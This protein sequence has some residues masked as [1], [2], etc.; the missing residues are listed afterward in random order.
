MSRRWWKLHS[1]H[2]WHLE[3]E[4]I[5]TTSFSITPEDWV[6]DAIVQDDWIIQNETEGICEPRVSCWV[7]KWTSLLDNWVLIPF[8]VW[9]SLKDKL[10]IVRQC[11]MQIG[12]DLKFSLA[13]WVIAVSSLHEKHGFSVRKSWDCLRR[14]MLPFMLK[15]DLS[16]MFHAQGPQTAGERNH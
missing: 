13:V 7:P 4:K 15:H 2:W 14:M 3:E 6:W 5:V 9:S 12:R 8:V 11:C 10:I 1:L 16:S